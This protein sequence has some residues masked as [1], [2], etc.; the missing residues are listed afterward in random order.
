M[1][2]VYKNQL[3]MEKGTQTINN[4]TQPFLQK[5]GI[6]EMLKNELHTLWFHKTVIYENE[7]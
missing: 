6:V 4:Y 7:T 3:H 1:P 2:Y 5:S